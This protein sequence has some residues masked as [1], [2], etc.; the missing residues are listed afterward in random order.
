PFLERALD[1][2]DAVTRRKAADLLAALPDSRLVGRITAAAGSILAL[3]DGALSPVFP[4]EVT[5]AMAR[6]GIVRAESAGRPTSPRSAADW[7]RL[8][9]QTVG[10]I[11]PAHWETRFGLEPEALVAAAMAGKWPRTLI[12]ALATAALRRR[13]GRWIDA[14]LAADGY[15]E[16]TG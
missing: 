13:D 9:I 15:G 7:S 14:L 1:D 4:G 11:S 3:R 12:T 16:R 10:V 2:R 8:L 5:D 6:D